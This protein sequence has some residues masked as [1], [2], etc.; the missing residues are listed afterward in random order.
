M[1]AT[2]LSTHAELVGEAERMAGA[3]LSTVSMEQIA[4]EV[5][6]ALTGIV[7]PRVQW[8]LGTDASTSVGAGF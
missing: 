1:L 8:R 4:C 3:L 6:S 7:S 5:E 2:L